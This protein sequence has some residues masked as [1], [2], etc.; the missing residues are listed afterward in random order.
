MLKNYNTYKGALEFITILYR[1]S[2]GNEI[3]GLQ[4]LKNDRFYE[5]FLSSLAWRK[6]EH[7]DEKAKDTLEFCLKYSKTEKLTEQAFFTIL[8]IALRKNCIINAEYFYSLFQ[9]SDMI[10]R[11]SFLGYLMLKAYEKHRII[12]KLIKNSMY[13][14]VQ[15]IDIELVQLWETIL[16]WFT[17]LNDIYIRDI[18]SKSL[19]NLLRVYPNSIFYLLEKF[20]YIEDDYLQSSL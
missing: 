10:Q 7:I 8:E 2:Y 19:T 9:H 16:S 20:K 1:E 13:I 12:T 4:N 14:K 17:S 6:D 3:I 5:L 11:D 18:A 15:D